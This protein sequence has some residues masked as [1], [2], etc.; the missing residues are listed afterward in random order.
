MSLKKKITFEELVQENR[1]QILKD[2]LLMEQIEQNLESRMHQ[3][4]RKLDQ[5]KIN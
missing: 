1:Q 4:V 2:K 5:K 3:T